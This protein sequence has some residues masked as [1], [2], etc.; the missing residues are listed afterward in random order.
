[1]SDTQVDISTCAGPGCPM[2]GTNSRSTTGES[3]WFCSIHFSTPAKDWH[4]TTHELNR[5][6]WLV[7]IVRGLR[8]LPIAKNWPAL[9]VKARDL[10]NES[11]CSEMNMKDSETPIAWMIRLEGI[12]A[13]SCK[14]SAV[15]A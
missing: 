9:E 8:A 6:R 7:G 11:R 2:L 1:M 12:L 15:Q 5:L 3:E 10:I 14:D 4:R 13:Q